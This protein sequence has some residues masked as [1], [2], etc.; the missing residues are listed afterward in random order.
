MVIYW[1][2]AG[3]PAH[4]S[5]LCKASM[6]QLRLVCCSRVREVSEVMLKLI[7]LAGK[8]DGKHPSVLCGELFESGPVHPKVHCCVDGEP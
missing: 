5:A 3:M 6:V 8:M 2:M 7:E 4:D 1:S